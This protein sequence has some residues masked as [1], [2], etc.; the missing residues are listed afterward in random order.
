MKL[1]IAR[2]YSNSK[3]TGIHT[4]MFQIST[5]PPVILTAHGHGGVETNPW[6]PK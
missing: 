1:G 2:R 4:F 3:A 6:K 5:H